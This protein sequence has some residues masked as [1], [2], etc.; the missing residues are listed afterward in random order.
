MASYM[1]YSEP[2]AVILDFTTL[3]YEW[4]DEMARIL[5][6]CSIDPLDSDLRIP[7]AVIISGL[8]RE[9]ITSLVLDEMDEEPCNW[10]Y[11]SLDEAIAAIE[12]KLA[13]DRML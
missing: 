5:F 3:R 7:V 6:A 13:G 4:G 8:N 12:C 1:T 11:Q 9:G 10:I 2:D